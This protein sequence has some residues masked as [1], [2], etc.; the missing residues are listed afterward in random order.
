M[1]SLVSVWTM[2]GSYNSFFTNTREQDRYFNRA[3]MDLSLV[4][5]Q[6]NVTRR[7]PASTRIL[8]NLLQ[9]AR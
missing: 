9:G 3:K 4:T 5:F 6:L 7:H 1:S 8:A 2:S